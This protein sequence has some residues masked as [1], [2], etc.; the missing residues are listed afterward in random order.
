MVGKSVSYHHHLAWQMQLATAGVQRCRDDRDGLS[1][2]E[3]IFGRLRGRLTSSHLIPTHLK[4]NTQWMFPNFWS[5]PIFPGFVRPWDCIVPHGQVTSRLRSLFLR[6][7]S[8]NCLFSQNPCGC[9]ERCGD[10]WIMGSL[11]SSSAI[12]PQQQ[13]NPGRYDYTQRKVGPDMR[14]AMQ[15]YVLGAVARRV[16]AR[17]WK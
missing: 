7:W 16:C 5:R 11:P 12:S 2:G 14:G 9:C 4:D 3:Y 15:C 1:D 13:N 17:D 6:I 10:V 8:H